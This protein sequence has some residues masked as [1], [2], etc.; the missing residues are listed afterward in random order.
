VCGKSRGG[1]RTS[2]G[3]PLSCVTIHVTFLVWVFSLGLPTLLFLA[4]ESYD[5]STFK[6][7]DICEVCVRRDS[8]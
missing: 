6:R 3:L 5:N 7:D 1:H 2:D 4:N 8:G